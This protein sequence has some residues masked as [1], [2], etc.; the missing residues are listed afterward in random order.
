[1]T[2]PTHSSL[3]TEA[4]FNRILSDLAAEAERRRAPVFDLLQEAT[5]HYEQALEAISA[6]EQN[7]LLVYDATE[8]VVQKSLRAI[9]WSCAGRANDVH[10]TLLARAIRILQK[11]PLRIDTHLWD[12]PCDSFVAATLLVRE[13]A[14]LLNHA[15][16]IAERR[17][18]P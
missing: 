3:A 8:I 2:Q 14:Q 7:L 9:L 16:Q 11:V 4:N 18:T 1:M 17:A 15:R 12:R 10:R 6:P 13:A 5:T